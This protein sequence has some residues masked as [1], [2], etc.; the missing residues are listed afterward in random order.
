MTG[1]SWLGPPI[2]ARPLS[3]PRQAA[4]TAPLE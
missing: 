1:I 4:F 3:A 2:D